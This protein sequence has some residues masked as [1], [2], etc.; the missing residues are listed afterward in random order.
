VK[1]SDIYGEAARHLGASESEGG[2]KAFSDFLVSKGQATPDAEG[3]LRT[4]ATT[5]G[6]LKKDAPLQRELTKILFGAA[7]PKKPTLTEAIGVTVKAPQGPTTDEIL[8]R[9]PLD[10]RDEVKAAF[11][12]TGDKIT[13]ASVQK[14]VAGARRLR[15][16]PGTVGEIFAERLRQSKA[17]EA[18][19]KLMTQQAAEHLGMSLPDAEEFLKIATPQ[20]INQAFTAAQTQGVTR[21]VR[22]LS[23]DLYESVSAS[24]KTKRPVTISSMLVQNVDK[25]QFVGTPEQLQ[26]GVGMPKMLPAPSQVTRPRPAAID[27]PGR[28]GYRVVVWAGEK[29]GCRDQPQ[30]EQRS[31]YPPHPR[32][33]RGPSTETSAGRRTTQT[34]LNTPVGS[35]RCGTRVGLHRL[36]AR[37]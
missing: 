15:G 2:L 7:G 6:L 8:G 10:I 14:A 11:A 33:T 19:S 22:E 26:R 5:S 9:V 30:R 20:E 21:D 18:A 35:P 3:V 32:R 17:S 29:P 28:C 13:E 24:T 36:G 16:Q 34:G 37:R 25:R 4:S 1:V 12:A 27:R 31:G 23:G